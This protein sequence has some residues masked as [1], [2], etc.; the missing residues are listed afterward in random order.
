MEKNIRFGDLV[1]SS[2]RP[3]THTL[4]TEA[5]EDKQ[6]HQAIKKI[7]LSLSFRI[8]PANIRAM[9]VSDSINRQVLHI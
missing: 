2:G 6:L 4:W 5:K 7:R 8:P 9:A 1:R 3:Q